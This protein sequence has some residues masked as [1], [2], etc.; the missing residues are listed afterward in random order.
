M[1]AE[2]N[3]VK[4]AIDEANTSLLEYAKTM[5][6]VEW[7]YFDFVQDR[8]SQL[9]QE[10]NFLIDLLDRDELFDD[11]GKL[12]DAGMATLGL[13]GQNY[14]IL[15]AQADQ[16]RDEMLKVNKQLADDPYNTEILKRREELLKLQQESISAAEDER[17][18]II[19]LVHNGIDKQL[20]ALKTLISAYTDSLDSAKDYE[21]SPPYYERVWRISLN[22]WKTLRATL[23]T[24]YG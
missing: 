23:A 15:M 16:Y 1:Q 20:D 4:E 7:G 14:N 21:N 11:G 6:E 12:T 5:R 19:D 13:R 2:I 8:I 17:D 24:T 10:S 9:T 3:G 22:C 18:A